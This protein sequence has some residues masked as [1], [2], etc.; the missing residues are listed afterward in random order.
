M[1]GW[2]PCVDVSLVDTLLAVDATPRFEIGLV[3]P[4]ERTTPLGEAQR[5]AHRDPQAEARAKAQADES[6]FA[7]PPREGASATSDSPES[8]IRAMSK[9]REQ[10]GPAGRSESY[11][12]SFASRSMGDQE[13]PDSFQSWSMGFEASPDL[14]WSYPSGSSRPPSAVGTPPRDSGRL[15]GSREA[16]HL[17]SRSPETAERDRVAGSRTA[18]RLLDQVRV[19]VRLRHYSR[20]TEHAYVQWVRRFILFHAKRH[21]RELGAPDIERFLTHLAVD[22]SV[23]ASTQNQALN[24]LVF[25]YREVLRMDAPVLAEIVR[26]R[27]PRRLPVVLTQDEVRAVLEQLQGAAWLVA[28]LL[29]GSGLRLL[30]CLTLR[31]KDI[32]F[33]THEIRVR[34]GK[35]RRDRVAPLPKKLVPAIRTH[36]ERAR[37]IHQEDLRQGFGSVALPGAIDVK[38]PSASR[39][40]SW[41]WV[42]P[43]TSR[44]YDPN[45]RIERRHHLHETA[46]QRAMK[47]AVAN[48]G[49]TKPATCHTLR[50][51]FATHLLGSGYD[52]RTVQ[53]LLGHHSVRTTMIY[54][55]VLNR[56]GLGVRS[57]LDE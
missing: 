2:I 47:N 16:A 48:S 36:L 24:A 55:H 34:D 46:V 29:Y 12:P 15:T 44:Y 6:D 10:P 27:K 35:G 45:A 54:T 52:I 1:N 49:I 51:S 40:W 19:A 57:P 22:R 32:D 26:A 41:Q 56:G 53:E 20:S 42:F 23:S 30:E 4:P 39:S 18:P 3:E 38:Y 43:A 28:A 5:E 14:E 21:P 37:V 9:H 11:R 50:H 33:E 8:R 17:E 31:I 13:E 25:L 7:A